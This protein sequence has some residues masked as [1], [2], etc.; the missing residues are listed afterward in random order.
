MNR[1]RPTIMDVARVAGVS[2]ATVSRVINKAPGAS[3]QLRARVEAA[4]A[5][6]GFLP[7]PTARALASGRHRAVDVVAFACGPPDIRWLGA[8]P[9]YSRVLSGMMSLLQAQDVQMRIHAVNGDS[10][11]GEIDAIAER[12]TV[13]AVL[14]SLPPELASRFYSRCRQVV[15]LVATSPVVPA[16]EADNAGGTRAAVEHLYALGRRRIA[17]IHGPK[18]NTCATARRA[19][20]RNAMADLGLPPIEAHGYFMRE[21]GRA[22]AR[23]LLERCPDLDAMVVASDLMAAG[24]VQAITASGRSVPHDVAL[25][26]FDDS[27]AAECANPPL[28]TMRVPVEEMAAA[29]TRL[30]LTGD[31]P[32]GHRQY[33]PVEL[34]QRESAGHRSG[35]A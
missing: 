32:P 20:Y 11:P 31:V 4:V 21:S 6:L 35:S 23:E 15:S 16:I 12:V 14:T 3:D 2:R 8:D 10:G 13:G 24:A 30:L 29:A 26:G 5:E 18:D 28:T 34:V 22:A 33:F 19:G 25:V 1:S 9:Y 17:A 27:I 7:D